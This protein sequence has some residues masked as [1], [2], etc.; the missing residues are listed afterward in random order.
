MANEEVKSVS[1]S[2]S[3]E[4]INHH[5]EFLQVDIHT[6]IVQNSKKVT[7][8]A[9]Y[10]DCVASGKSADA[11]L[12]DL[13]ASDCHI[14][15]LGSS[16]CVPYKSGEVQ[17]IFNPGVLNLDS[18]LISVFL[19]FLFL[20]LF[21]AAVRLSKKSAV[22]NLFLTAVEMI[23]GFVN[24]SVKDIFNVRNR[25]I[26]P[27]SLTVFMWVF[28]MN[29]LDLLPVDLLPNICKSIGIPY[30]RV[31]PSADVNITMA[32]SVSV[33]LL[34]LVYTFRYKGIRGFVS[35]YALHPFNTWLLAP[36]NIFL[37]GVSLLAKPVSLGLRLFGNMYAGETIF[38]LITIFFGFSPA[39]DSYGFCAGFYATLA[40]LFGFVWL[41]GNRGGATRG[42]S[43]ALTL[44]ALAAGGCAVAG[45]TGGVPE[46][47][48]PS[49]LYY[50]GAL[51]TAGALALAW[52]YRDSKGKMWSLL[53]AAVFIGA[54]A[55]DSALRGAAPIGALAGIILNLVWA[56]FHILII[57]LQAFIFMIL[58][59]VYL[60]SASSAE[61]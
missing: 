20:G 48:E 51:F 52:L 3:T 61:E 37:E 15:D 2:G 26:A 35:D 38:I 27:L 5:L 28:A 6:G 55:A 59:I 46:I 11:C 9:A 16:V 1:E 41:C 60:A 19:G 31:V 23:V 49:V 40:V 7:S 10:N 56:L 43:C 50:G 39:A 4:Y 24:S 21:A 29:L 22:P 36:V 44:L 25:F 14:R 30:L 18:T 12:A 57:F 58:T 47:P 17:G 32:M 33:F 34:I 8:V 45:L 42:L 53:A 13:N 54:A